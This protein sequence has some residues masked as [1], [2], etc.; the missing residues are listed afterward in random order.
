MG[1]YINPS[2]GY[3]GDLA[4]KGIQPKNH[5]KDNVK[6]MR[7]KQLKL[8]QEKDESDI[9]E[10]RAKNLYKLPQFQNVESR[11]HHMDSARSKED[12]DDYDSGNPKFL[13]RGVSQLRREE[14][15][16]E[17]RHIRQELEMKLEQEAAL[18]E[19]PTT[20]RKASVPRANELA[21]VAGPTNANFIQRNKLSAITMPAQHKTDHVDNEARHEHFGKVPAYLEERKAKWAADEQE[22][23]RRMPD[24]DCPHGMRLMPES[25]RLETL[26]VLQESREEALSQMR[27]LPFVIETPTMKK[28]QEVL[29]NKLREIDHALSIFTKTK[30]YVADDR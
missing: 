25:E 4:K 3:R 14:I 16:K 6:E 9:M 17:N 18:N 19:K 7:M 5:M 15:A 21:P 20:P 26:R 10:K 2:N 1:S 30:V 24:P 29:E 11:L 13:T 8:K 22:I 27:R 12:F 28:K 23:R